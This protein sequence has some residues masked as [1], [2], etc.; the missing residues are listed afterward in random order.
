[1]QAN[2]INNYL[3]I[4]SSIITTGDSILMSLLSR[5]YENIKDRIWR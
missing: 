1:M 4:F 5:S 2:T 3:K